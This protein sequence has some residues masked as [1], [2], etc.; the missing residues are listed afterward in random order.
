MRDPVYRGVIRGFRVIF[1]LLG[2]RFRLDGLRSGDVN[3]DDRDIDRAVP[4]VA[5]APAPDVADRVEH[6]EEE[7]EEKDADAD[8]V[9]LPLSV[10]A[11][12]R[13]P[14]EPPSE[15][16]DDDDGEDREAVSS[17]PSWAA[18]P[19]TARA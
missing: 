19:R 4:V 2:L 6:D 3:D 15:W 17:S 10:H 13:N 8:E 1:R 14:P 11:S 12:E 9:E 16:E 7:D 5:R 18:G